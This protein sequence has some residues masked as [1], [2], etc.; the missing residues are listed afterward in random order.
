MLV[1]TAPVEMPRTVP[2][3]G[4]W[5]TELLS[6]AQ[7]KIEPSGQRTPPSIAQEKRL[8]GAAAAMWG[9]AQS[10]SPA[11]PPADR[12]SISVTSLLGN[13]LQHNNFS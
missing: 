2:M 7:R 11:P 12:N 5:P 9:R 8:A 1:S 10:H 3:N 6:I 4:F 13:S